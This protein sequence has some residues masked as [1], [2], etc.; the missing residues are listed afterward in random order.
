VLPALA[1]NYGVDSNGVL[2]IN[3]VA[4]AIVLAAGSLLGVLIP[5]NWDRRLTYAGAGLANALGAVVLLAANRPSIYFA[6]TLIYLLTAGLC[7]ARA[8]ALI[9][10]VVGRDIS[11]ASTWFSALTA[12]TNIPL[13]SMIWLEGRMF[14]HFGVHGLLWTDVAGNLLVFAIVA[15]FFLTRRSSRPSIPVAPLVAKSPSD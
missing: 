9:M 4:G 13:A 2:W 12:I 15:A 8:V 10:D 5:G 11:D 7:L 3:G 14:G 6:G 1:S